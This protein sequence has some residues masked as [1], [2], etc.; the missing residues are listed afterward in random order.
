[1]KTFRSL[2]NFFAPKSTDNS[3]PWTANLDRLETRLKCLRRTIFSSDILEEGM[4][5]K[6]CASIPVLQTM[7]NERDQAVWSDTSASTGRNRAADLTSLTKL[8]HLRAQWDQYLA[9][10]TDPDASS[11]PVTFPRPPEDPSAKWADCISQCE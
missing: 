11:L 10:P 7:T 4:K 3:S 2:H 6:S 9:D 8:F 5:E 1:M